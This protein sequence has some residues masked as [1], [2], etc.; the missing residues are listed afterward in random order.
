ME[1][2][3]AKDMT[4]AERAQTLAYIIKHGRTAEPPP[5]PDPDA[6]KLAKDMSAQERSAWL[7]AHRRRFP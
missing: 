1:Q 6:P 2:K 3:L 5:P 4:E 7:A